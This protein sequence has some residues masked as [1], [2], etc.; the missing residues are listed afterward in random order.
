ML[1]AISIFVPTPSVHV[2][3]SGFSM[4]LG[5]LLSAENEPSPDRISGLFVL[6]T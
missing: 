6:A 4:C 3:S 1:R 5:I 2:T